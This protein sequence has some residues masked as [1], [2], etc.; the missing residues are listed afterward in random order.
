[1]LKNH[2]FKLL[3]Q[4]I[5]FELT[6]SQL[7]MLKKLSAYITD[8]SDDTIFMVKGYAGTGKTTMIRQLVNTLDNFSIPSV[9]LAPTGRAAKVLMSYTGKAAF[10]MHKKIYRQMSSN[11]GMGTFVLDKNMHKSSFFIVDEASMISNHAME[12]SVFGSGKLLDD[13]LEYVYSGQGCKLIIVGDT[14]QLPPVG[15]QISPALEYKTIEEYGFSVLENILTDVVRQQSDS[16]ILLNATAIRHHILKNALPMFLK[17]DLDSLGGVEKVAGGELIE[18]LGWSYDNFGIQDTIILT[19][20]NKQANRYNKGV[21]SSILFRDSEIARGDLL[22][23]VKNNYFWSNPEDNI[24]FIANGDIAEIKHIYG[25]E[26]IYGFKFADVSLRFIDYDDVELDCKILMDTL[27]I[28]GPAL[29]QDDNRR[30]FY[31]ISEDYQDIRNKKERWK[32]IRLDPYFNA[33]QVKF[34][35]AITCHKAQG[36]QWRSVFVDTGYITHEML[37]SEFYRWLYTAF[38][39]STDKLFLVNFNKHFFEAEY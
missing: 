13:L 26:Q 30:L 11:D 1:M 16:G 9:L 28:D 31:S 20:S 14:A 5:D 39:R 19:R 27:D 8:I 33:L 23:I 37:T 24:E 29:S 12:N 32:K 22:M 35:Y 15:I 34:A 25:Y 18:K 3:V 6:D 2:V 4:D 36:G 7:V 10:T 38:T 21:R 17:L